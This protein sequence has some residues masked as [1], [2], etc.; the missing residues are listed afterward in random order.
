MNVLYVTTFNKNIYKFSGKP[1]LESFLK[2][3]KDDILCC[4]E[5][6]DF[7]DFNIHQVKKY[8]LKDSEFLHTWLKENSDVIPP[9]Y[10]GTADAKKH[11]ESYFSWNFRAAGWFRKIVSM[12]KA[13]DFKDKYDAIVFIDSDSKILQSIST[14]LISK[15][16]KDKSC[17]YHWGKI[18][19]DNGLAVESGFIGFKTDD[20]G[21]NLLELWINKFK[22]KVFKRYLRWDDGGMFSNV[23]LENNFKGT[24]D[25]VTDYSDI[26]KS[27]SHVID[28]GIFKGYILHEKGTHKRN[29]VISA[30]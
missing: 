20:V 30:K 6:F 15:A 12:S 21:V 16:F 5:G 14:E 2:N 22:N 10:G 8:N 9:E 13:L 27:Q 24:I 23:L 3:Q 19:A 1:M 18:R 28:R 11:P 29:G 7:K 25:L 26:G 17:F 4:F